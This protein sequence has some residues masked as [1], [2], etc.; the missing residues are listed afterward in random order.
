[1]T[2]REEIAL[3]LTKTIL[4]NSSVAKFTDVSTTVV[5]IYNDI[6]KGIETK[7]EKPMEVLK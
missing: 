3:S 2:S 7:S 1:M 4:E 6:Y 5:S